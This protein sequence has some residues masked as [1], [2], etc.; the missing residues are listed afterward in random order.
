MGVA[1][2]S[3]LLQPDSKTMAKLMQ[4]SLDMHQQMKDENPEL[5]KGGAIVED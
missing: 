4:R 5:Y 2:S 3:Q 1:A